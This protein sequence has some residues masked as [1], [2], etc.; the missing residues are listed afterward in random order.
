MNGMTI[1]EINKFFTEKNDFLLSYA[2]KKCQEFKRNYSPED[3]IS[4]IYIKIHRKEFKD[5]EHL[6]RFTLKLM[7]DIKLKNSDLNRVKKQHITEELIDVSI[8]EEQTNPVIEYY[9][10][11]KN[12][13]HKCLLE[14]YIE[15]GYT[16]HIK[17]S[18]YFGLSTTTINRLFKEIKQN[19]ITKYK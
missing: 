14:A 6:E 4:E 2:L 13:E 19:I 9:E 10:T 17:L 16:S 12:T 7:E 15:L 3:V 5:V 8:E 18:E 1:V 11:T